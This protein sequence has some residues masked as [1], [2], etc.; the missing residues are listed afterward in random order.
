MSY[1]C[2]GNDIT[3]SNI[4]YGSKRLHLQVGA[5]SVRTLKGPA[6]IDLFCSLIFTLYVTEI[7]QSECHYDLHKQETRRNCRLRA[8]AMKAA[9]PGYTCQFFNEQHA[10]TPGA[11]EK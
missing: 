8:A 10:H 2:G 4:A 7:W 9:A 5:Y 3:R 6:T 1:T 11:S